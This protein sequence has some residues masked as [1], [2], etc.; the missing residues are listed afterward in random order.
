M[1]FSTLEE[2]TALWSAIE[3][4]DKKRRLHIALKALN[5][6]IQKSVVT[7]FV[8]HAMERYIAMSPNT[9]IKYKEEFEQ[10]L[11]ILYRI[12]MCL[13]N[14]DLPA[15]R[16]RELEQLRLNYL[17]IVNGTLELSTGPIE[18]ESFQLPPF[19]DVVGM[20][21][22]FL[23]ADLID[24][25]R[26]LLSSITRESDEIADE[27]RNEMFKLLTKK[28]IDLVKLSEAKKITHEELEWQ[29]QC[30]LESVKREHNA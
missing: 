25:P 23:F 29:L 1:T 4:R 12:Q 17:A 13:A 20:L 27:V 2:I 9:A 21:R 22:N 14:G 19:V 5:L 16:N 28:G 6:K 15:E 18:Y 30:L 10:V 24:K 7:S 11:A 26:T 8:I 3:P